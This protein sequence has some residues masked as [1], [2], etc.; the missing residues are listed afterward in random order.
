[1]SP[2]A[3]ELVFMLVV[4]KLPIL[5]LCGV[6]WW[7]IRAEPRPLEGAGRTV[8]PLDRPPD[9][10]WGHGRPRRPR[11]RRRGPHGSPVRGYPRAGLGARARV[12]P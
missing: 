12:E 11:G 2:A 10:R 9:G 3:A 8:E 5:Y 4:L 6:V 7:A 1:V